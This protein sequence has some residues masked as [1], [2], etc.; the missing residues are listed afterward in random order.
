MAR[1]R[2]SI[3]GAFAGVTFAAL[4]L[5]AAMAWLPGASDWSVAVGGLGLTT[6]LFAAMCEQSGHPKLRT[7]LHSALFYVGGLACL[8]LGEAVPLHGAIRSALAVMVVAFASWSWL[9]GPLKRR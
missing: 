9:G 7:L 2:F 5:T 6:I 8:A 3:V 4:T 1:F